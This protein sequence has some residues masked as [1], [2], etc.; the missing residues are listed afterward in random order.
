ML[1]ATATTS[2]D[3]VE[4]DSMA[5]GIRR[6]RQGIGRRRLRVGVAVIGDNEIVGNKAWQY[7]LLHSLPAIL[8]DCLLSLDQNSSV[9]YINSQE[10][11]LSALE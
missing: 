9:K 8:S 6:K 5:V 7:F 3:N 4:N 1:D 11:N 2:N 10:E